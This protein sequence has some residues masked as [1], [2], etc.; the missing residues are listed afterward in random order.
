ME[1]KELLFECLDHIPK[2]KKSQQYAKMVGLTKEEILRT[3]LKTIRDVNHVDCDLKKL[4]AD[5][6]YWIP[7]FTNQRFGNIYEL[8]KI[9]NVEPKSIFYD[10][11]KFHTECAEHPEIDPNDIE[12]DFSNLFEEGE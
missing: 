4:E 12:H 10:L 2:M 9:I 11:M 8:S 7:V 6:L 3:Q 1:Y 5:F